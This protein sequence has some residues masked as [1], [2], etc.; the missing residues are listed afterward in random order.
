MEKLSYRSGIKPC[1]FIQKALTTLLIL[2]AFQLSGQRLN[3]NLTKNSLMFNQTDSIIYKFYLPSSMETT[4]KFINIYGGEEILF[5]TGEPRAR[6]WHEIMLHSDSVKHKHGN[7][8]SGVYYLDF[9]GLN[10]GS[11]ALT[12]NSFQR[13]W[14]ETITAEKITF[15]KESGEIS[16]EI[17][18]SCIAKTRIGFPNGALVR[19]LDYGLPK[20]EGTHTAHWDGYD[21][22]GKMYVRQMEGL[23]ARVIAYTIPNTAFILK[24]DLLP[25]DVNAAPAYP[26]NYNRLALGSY[27]KRPY[28]DDFDI[29]VEYEVVSMKDDMLHLIFGEQDQDFSKSFHPENEIY[30]H[31]EGIEPV[32]TYG[33][34]IPGEYSIAYTLIPK[35]KHLVLVNVIIFP[36]NRIAVGI[37][38]L[39]ID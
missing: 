37:K 14:G 10:N 29:A 18:E 27:A 38:E 11:P 30:I 15:N 33:V 32:E 6:G 35:G 3:I 21:Q 34:A 9:T 7:L 39:T 2:L 23:T 4:I 13:P 28:I 5:E 24:N 1:R 31:V 36:E 17:K 12:F 19:T 8:S 25:A 22:S 20:T 16:F 26:E